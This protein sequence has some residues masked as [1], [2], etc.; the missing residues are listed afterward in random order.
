MK[1]KRVCPVLNF[2]SILTCARTQIHT[3]LSPHTCLH[4]NIHTQ[5]HT[6]TPQWR[7]CRKHAENDTTQQQT[8]HTPATSHIFAHISHICNYNRSGVGAENVLKMTLRNSGYVRPQPL[9]PHSS[10]WAMPPH[11]AGFAGTS[12]STS[13]NRQA[14]HPPAGKCER[15]IEL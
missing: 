8:P 10:T 1:R 7:G 5:T 9:K 11:L 14:P 15:M 13:Y 12:A 6:N 3:P 2:T 4:T